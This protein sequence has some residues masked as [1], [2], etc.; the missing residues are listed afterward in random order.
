MRTYSFSAIA[1]IASAAGALLAGTPAQAADGSDDGAG[2]PTIVLVHGAWEQAS[3]WSLVAERL[4]AR[5]YRVV[6]PELPLRT[7]AGDAAVVSDVVD[8]VDGPVV[9]AGHSYGGEVIS[10]AAGDGAK[11]R[12]LVFIAAFAPDRGESIFQLGAR[13]PVSQV[14]E[15][16]VPVPVVGAGGETGVDL[17]IN[18]LLYGPVFA[19]DVPEP[20]ATQMAATQRPLTLA[21]ALSGPTA[22]PA[23]KTIASWYLVARDDR[24]IPAATERFMAKRANATTV[25]IASSHAAP[26]S[27]PGAVTDLIARAAGSAA[28][29]VAAVARLRLT[30]SMF[31]AART[32]P[33]VRV[34]AAQT[35]ARVSYTLDAPA[36]VRFTVERAVEGRGVGG[37]CV[38]PAT[39]NRGRRACTRFAAVRGGFSRARPAGPDRFTFTARL[40]GRALP[41][42]RYRLVATP[43]AAGRVGMPA[44]ARFRVV[45]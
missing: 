10:S 15:A 37:R 44:R 7:L 11:V 24:A 21:A 34:A 14:P 32:G 45:A 4:R 35:A 6:A 9:L 38:A 8:D 28:S 25:E 16:L 30:P 22:A 23:W 18:S 41:P 12:A 39:S 27:H 36:S 1:A 13:P 43:T 19:G 5:G 42:S 3:S 17:Y 20:T 2:G 29:P 40:G 31:R 33:A 26:V